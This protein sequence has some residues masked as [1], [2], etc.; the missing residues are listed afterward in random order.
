MGLDVPV[1]VRPPGLLVTVYAV[2][3]EPPLVDG[4][5]NATLAWPLP[6]VT[7][8]IVGTPGSWSTHEPFV[9][10]APA[11][12]TLPHAPQSLTL[13][14]T[15]VSQPFTL[16]PSQLPYPATHAIPQPDAVHVGTEFGPLQHWTPQ[17]LQFDVVFVGVSQPSVGLW[18]QLPL[19]SP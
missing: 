4:A 1:A 12:Q 7:D 6:T 14:K 16:L 15:L 11:A 8:V 2:M 18:L 19:Q 9:Q 13:V 5:V 10:R 17:P 3:G